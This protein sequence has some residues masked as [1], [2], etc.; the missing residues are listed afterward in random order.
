MQFLTN[1]NI[2]FMRYRLALGIISALLSVVALILVFSLKQLNIGID[3]AGGT[4]VTLRFQQEP[5]LQEL[6]DVLNGAGLPEARLQRFGTVGQQEVLIRTATVEGSQE[7]SSEAL[8]KALDT[9]YNAAATKGF[10]LNRQGADALAALLSKSDPDGVVVPQEGISP[11]LVPPDPHYVEIAGKIL[12][13]RKTDGLIRSWDQVEGI[14]GVSP[15]AV[16]VL[17]SRTELGEYALLSVENVGP[18]IGS[19]LKTKGIWAVIFS[20]AGMLLYIA[21]RFELRFGVGAVVASLH[22]VTVVLGLYAWLGYEFNLTTIAAFLTL[23][24]Y[25]VNDTVVVFDRVRENMQRMRR[26]SLYSVLN[27][28]LNQ[29]LTRTIMTSG[30]TL[31]VAASLFFFGG[32][33]I[34]GFAFIL[35]VG[36]IIGTYSSVYVASPVVLAW[37]RYFGSEAKARKA[38]AKR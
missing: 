4:Q 1:T 34:H 31:L 17:K 9:R 26:E 33:V 3:F 35:M 16:S 12:A 2:D 15:A 6:R 18:Q 24:G 19:E 22:D 30:T 20:L 36:V 38:V 13:L 8:L 14:D 27:L 25:S 32:E 7:G 21:L 10:D 11:E 28:S 37:E 23:V 29:T 5:D